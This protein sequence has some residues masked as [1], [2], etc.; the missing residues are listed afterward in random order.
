MPVK[1]SRDSTNEDYNNF[2]KELGVIDNTVSNNKKNIRC[3]FKSKKFE[4]NKYLMISQSFFL[5]LINS[6]PIIYSKYI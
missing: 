6:N 2:L 5:S 3:N 4:Y 1:Y